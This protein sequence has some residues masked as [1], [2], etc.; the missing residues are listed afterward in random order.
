MEVTKQK[1]CITCGYNH[2]EKFCP[3][4]GE[5]GGLRK[6]SFKTVL[7]EAL[8]TFINMDKGYLYNL[9]A[10]TFHPQ[11][12]IQDYLSGKRK[13]I[14]NPISYLIVSISLYLLFENFF[15]V[16]KPPISSEPIQDTIF[17]KV[18]YEAGTIITNYFKFFWFISIFIL[19]FPSTLIFSTKNYAEHVTISSFIIGHATLLAAFLT[20]LI[21]VPLIFN[22]VLYS[23]ILI[24][25]YRF[26]STPGDKFG[27]IIISFL[28]VVIFFIE[29]FLLTIFLGIIS[30]FLF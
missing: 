23:F 29:L 14:F 9:R 11:V 10:L 5:V 4:C 13:G 24:L 21:H 26:Y 30:Y 20:P 16:E 6:I 27:S 25:Y 17:F 3:N 1:A 19:A 12:F 22:Y 18:G 15:P 8:S 2:K 28:V 7:E